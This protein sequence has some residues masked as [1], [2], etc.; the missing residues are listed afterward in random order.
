M[1]L[2]L[3]VSTGTF[4]PLYRKWLKAITSDRRERGDFNRPRLRHEIAS[5]LC[6]SQ[7]R[8]D[9]GNPLCGFVRIRCP[10]CGEEQLLFFRCKTR[11]FCPS[12]HAKRRE[13]W[14]DFDI[15]L[16]EPIDIQPGQF[17]TVT[18]G[19]ATKYHLVTTLI[20]DEVD[21]DGD[22]VS[23]TAEHPYAEIRVDAGNPPE[24]T[25]RT[26][27]ADA[28]GKWTVDFTVP[29]GQGTSYEVV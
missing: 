24:P 18:D 3:S 1:N 19:I 10:E 23:G 11:S 4:V 28:D 2:V 21:I 20:V 17:I 8:L 13:K 29:L 26:G 12:C 15:W 7:R 5:S 27:T 16:E 22:T 14:G 9:C 6:S 25:C